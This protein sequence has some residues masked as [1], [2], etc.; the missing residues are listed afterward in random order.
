MTRALRRAS[1]ALVACLVTVGLAACG[2]T[3]AAD[4]AF[5]K[6]AD[7]VTQ[8]VTWGACGSDYFIDAKSFS[9][10]F[11]KAKAKCATFRVPA[12]YDASA[13]L[14][15]F[16]IAAM[17]LPSTGKAAKKGVLFLNPGGPGESGVELVQWLD[18]PQAVLDRYDIVGFD[19]R[20]VSRSQPVSGNKVGCSDELDFATY[21]VGESSPQSQAETAESDAALEEYFADCKK[22][23]PAWWT[24]GTQNVVRDLDIMRAVMTGDA[25]L[26]FLGSSYGTTIAS[27][28]I[29]AFPQHVGHLI[30][31]SPTDNSSDRDDKAIINAKSDEAAL[32]RLIDGYARAK[33]KTR[34][35]VQQMMLQVRQWGD[36]DKLMGF[37]GMKPFPGNPSY[38][39][40]T[41]YMFTHGI[42][43]LTYYDGDYA[44]QLFNQALDAVHGE[45]WNGY[46]EDLALRLDG[47]DTEPMYRAFADGKPYSLKNLRR[48]N[49]FEVMMMVNGM[50]SDGRDKHTAAQRRALA[51]KIRVASPFWAK[52]E[53]NDGSFESD[54]PQPGNE[55]S[56]EA[57]DDAKI[58]DPPASIAARVNASGKQVM[59]IGARLESTTPYEFAVTTAKALKSPLVTYE[60]SGH[61]PLLSVPN[62]CLEKLF[63]DYLVNDRLPAGGASCPVQK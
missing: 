18:M 29:R 51:A 33:K 8:K 54:D 25:P 19:P 28:Y 24:L 42:T 4:R 46:F 39:L 12:V 15:D 40:S 32:M 34:A 10:S 58:P 50:D 31:N 22:R 43:S 5:D 2:D 11:S 20:G 57:F 53:A 35:Q 59:V 6:P 21:W 17:M 27:E 3:A 63:V 16:A 47:Y 26:D 48:N 7:Y 61:A 23:S 56:W 13:S 9:A 49:S 41:E 60:G 37:M 36:D 45:K 44:Q 14:P 38:R 55:W 52:L 62:K 1:A 30:L